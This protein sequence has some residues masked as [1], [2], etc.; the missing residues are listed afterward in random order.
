M[1]SR[2]EHYVVP[3]R[4][5][6]LRSEAVTDG[7]STTDRNMW[8]NLLGELCQQACATGRFKIVTH[9]ETASY[10]IVRGDVWDGLAAAGPVHTID[11]GLP[12]LAKQKRARKL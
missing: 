12:Q 7:M 6:R 9:A 5:P 1:P 2:A 11:S 8:A 3:A 10:A 4:L